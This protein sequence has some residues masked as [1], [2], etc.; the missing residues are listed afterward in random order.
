LV[1]KHFLPAAQ[2]KAFIETF[3]FSNQSIL[4]NIS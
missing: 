3:L 2:Q 4:E 1:P